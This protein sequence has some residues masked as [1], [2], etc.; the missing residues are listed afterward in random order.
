MDRIAQTK[1]THIIARERNVVLVDFDRDPDPPKPKFPGAGALRQP[2][3]D[4]LIAS[5]GAS[6]RMAA[7]P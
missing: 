3:D 7:G 6:A 2:C 5:V 1:R 4:A